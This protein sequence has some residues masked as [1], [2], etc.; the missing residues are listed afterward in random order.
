MKD[1]K[2]KKKSKD[3]SSAKHPK[4]DI[5][6]INDMKNEKGDGAKPEPGAGAADIGSS[7][8]SKEV[9]Q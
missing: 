1:S 6:E 4:N 8:S 2:N 3:S 7:D 5:K 9:V